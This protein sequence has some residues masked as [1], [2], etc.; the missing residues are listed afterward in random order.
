[1]DDPRD[2]SEIEKVSTAPLVVITDPHLCLL[3]NQ[4][5]AKEK[6]SSIRQLQWVFFE[7]DPKQC[8]ENA[9]TRE[10]GKSQVIFRF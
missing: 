7:N 3:S 10:R 9:K 8:L 1:M 4:K 6:F 2:F 5:A